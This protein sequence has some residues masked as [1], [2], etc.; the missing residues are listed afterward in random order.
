MGISFCFSF[1]F[2]VSSFSAICKASS[3]SHFA[4]LHFFFLGMVL[5]TTSCTTYDPPSIVLQ[6][7]C[8][9]DLISWINFSL[10]LY[11][12][13]GFDLGHIR[14]VVVFPTFFNL[15]LNLA[16]RSSWSEPQSAPG[17]V[18]CW[19]YRA[20]PCSAAKNQSDLGIGHLL[21]SI[22]RVTFY[23]AERGYLL[24]PVCSLGKTPLAFSQLHFVLQGQIC[25]LLQV[26]LDFLLLHSSPL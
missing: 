17:L 1:A 10:P 19:L 20:S 5:I 16:I 24:W 9:S 18:F 11:N 23:V 12:C 26:F 21:M 2:C 4:F 25:L 14:M 22:C 15:S 6:G 8:L 13:K 3:D 7:L